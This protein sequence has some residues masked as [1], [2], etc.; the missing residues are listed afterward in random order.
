MSDLYVL[1]DVSAIYY[2]F[3]LFLFIT[4]VPPSLE[5]MSMLHVE[6]A[7]KGLCCVNVIIRRCRTHAF[8]LGFPD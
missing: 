5:N 7:G 4:V 3:F 6:L 8:G 2:F 1:W